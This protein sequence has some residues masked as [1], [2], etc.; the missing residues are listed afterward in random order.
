MPGLDNNRIQAKAM[1]LSGLTIREIAASLGVNP[2]TVGSWTKRGNWGQ[3][4]AQMSAQMNKVGS[5]LV[6]KHS[7]TDSSLAKRSALIRQSLSYEVEDQVESLRSTPCAPEQLG[8]T[9]AG[10]GRAT[11]LKKITETAALIHGWDS[12]RSPGLIVITDMR[13]TSPEDLK[14]I[15]D[16]PEVH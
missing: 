2:N 12:E 7:F 16:A 6:T 15:T 3:I 13:Q 14:A 11:I 10:E 9:P 4:R 5:P 1:F 8:N